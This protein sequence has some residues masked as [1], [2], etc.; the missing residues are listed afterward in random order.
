MVIGE[1]NGKSWSIDCQKKNIIDCLGPTLKVG[2][3]WLL[4]NSLLLID[5][6]TERI[7]I[8]HMKKYWLSQH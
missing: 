6:I 2:K 8:D 4:E 3:N 5:E 7:P 1:K